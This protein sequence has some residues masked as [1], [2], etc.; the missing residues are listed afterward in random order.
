[1]NITLGE[2]TDFSLI[3]LLLEKNGF[4]EILS[5]LECFVTG[6]ICAK[7]PFKLLVIL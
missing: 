3:K 6:R 1:M 2:N 5:L 7:P 4:A